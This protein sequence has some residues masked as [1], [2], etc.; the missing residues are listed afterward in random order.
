MSR[1]GAAPIWEQLAFGVLGPP[2][3][4]LLFRF[5]VRV[6]ALTA[7]GGTVSAKT[8]KRQRIEFW[9]MLSIMYLLVIA[10]FIYAWLT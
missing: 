3:M 2:I 1:P 6:F 8:Q 4:A 5:M 9:G 7:Q 10:E